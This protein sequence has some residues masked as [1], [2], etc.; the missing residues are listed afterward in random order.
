MKH[1]KKII[2]TL[3]L[4]LTQISFAQ[5]VNTPE[6]N[7]FEVIPLSPEAASICK[8]GN[9]PVGYYSGT[10]NVTI[11]I[12]EIDLDGKKFP[13][14][15][16]YNT[17][18]IKVSQEASC[19]GLGWVLNA[20]GCISREIRGISDFDVNYGYCWNQI[21]DTLVYMLADISNPINPANAHY[22]L[23]DYYTG[24]KDA[25]PDVFNY[26]IPGYQGIM[27][28]PF[29]SN[30]PINNRPNLLDSV[31]FYRNEDNLR[32]VCHLYNNH[33]QSI[34]ED[35]PVW[36]IY[37]G[38]GYRY[39]FYDVEKNYY[40]N[41]NYSD[42][43]YPSYKGA[44]AISERVASDGNLY[45]DD[46]EKLVHPS[47]LLTQIISP[48]GN[49][50]TFEYEVDDIFTFP[51]RQ[52]LECYL[53]E[54]NNSLANPYRHRTYSTSRIKQLRLKTIRYQLSKITFNGSNRYDILPYDPQALPKCISQ[55]IVEDSLSTYRKTFNFEYTYMHNNVYSNIN[56]TDIQSRLVLKKI[57]T[58]DGNYEFTYNSECLPDKDS[59]AYDDYGYYNKT[60]AASSTWGG[61]NGSYIN[62]SVTYIP[63]VNLYGEAVRHLNGR[64]RAVSVEGSLAG[65]LTK[66]KYPTG[67]ETSFDYEGRTVT[68]FTGFEMTLRNDTIVIDSIGAIYNNDS[69]GI[70]DD[71]FS[72][73]LDIEIS[74]FYNIKYTIQRLPNSTSNA[75]MTENSC[76]HF[77]IIPYDENGNLQNNMIV[78]ESLTYADGLAAQYQKKTVQFS[79]RIPKG[80]YR[81]ELYIESSIAA[82]YTA[83]IGKFEIHQEPEINNVY[84]TPLIGGA[85][86]RRITNTYHEELLSKQ[87]FSYQGGKL[88]DLSPNYTCIVYKSPSSFADFLPSNVFGTF[89]VGS[90]FPFSS[91]NSF[92]QRNPVGYSIVEVKNYLS[93]NEY[94][95]QKYYYHNESDQ[96]LQYTK[97][98]YYNVGTEY[99]SYLSCPDLNNGELDTIKYYDSNGL[100]IKK[101]EYTYQTQYNKVIHG[102]QFYEPMSELISHIDPNRL[103]FNHEY[104]PIQLSAKLY[105]IPTS[106]RTINRTKTTT[107]YFSD[108]NIQERSVTKYLNTNDKPY[109]IVNYDSLNDSTETINHYVTDQGYYNS[110]LAQK[111]MRNAPLETIQLKNGHVISAEKT[112]YLYMIPAQ[113]YLFRSNTP[114]TLSN[115]SSFYQLEYNVDSCDAEHYYLPLQVSDRSEVPTSYLWSYDYYYPVAIIRG[116]SAQQLSAL[117]I[118]DDIGRSL[119]PDI[120]AITDVLSQ[121]PDIQFEIYTYDMW[122]NVINHRDVNGLQHNFIYDIQGRLIEKKDYNN[123]TREK[124]QYHYENNQ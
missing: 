74:D 2:F 43:T 79:K 67:L 41:R 24:R 69:S 51:K 120:E 90:S 124:Y 54:H 100:L 87:E 26:S 71:C 108:G 86:V 27:F 37:D 36:S 112:D 34:N 114:R 14:S 8:Y 22:Y 60:T 16:S 119:N 28:V 4:S 21:P 62:H 109:R 117:F 75:Y 102:I 38:D 96:P 70:R 61:T 77:Y 99:P 44:R 9:I 48:R 98:A 103:R 118:T 101:E 15:L 59:N 23:R 95:L 105:D 50:I 7:P 93:D 6:K 94:N 29:C 19:V 89:I 122:G 10:A 73:D 45:V 88:L 57:S 5:D 49:A 91:P 55:I 76:G 35:P 82:E 72:H 13:I 110:V 68:Q 123:R 83:T 121:V 66:V 81:C 30:V 1:I 104:M 97:T 40:F 11:P 58:D 25:E 20:G 63:E 53:L 12:H 115:F 116:M 92:T 46:Y 31:F 39:D 42:N 33:M 56:N 113:R 65:I 47:W 111:N 106:L 32:G 78:Y 52:D 84:L 18:G 3:C 80:R 17:T 64:S 107:K 85:R